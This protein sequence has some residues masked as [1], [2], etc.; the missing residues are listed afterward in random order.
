ME[1][2]GH[3]NWIYP[4][5]QFPVCLRSNGVFCCPS[6]PASST[7]QQQG[8]L[9][10]INWGKYGVYNLKQTS[11]STLEGHSSTNPQ[12]W[13]KMEKI[14]D[15]SDSEKVLLGNGGGSVWNFEWEK[16]SF[17]VE[18]LCDSINHFVCKQFPAHSHWS[19]NDNTVDIDWGKYGKYELVINPQTG[20]MS[21]FVKNNPS[22][23]RKAQF[24]RPLGLE[25]LA[26][27]PAHDHSHH[28]EHGESCSSGCKH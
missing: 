7:W 5:G 11:I 13:R 26:S 12:D 15:L 14:K 10:Q 21:G 25:A 9:I 18:F 8:D 4:S 24:L 17:E 6:F 3:Y 1:L 20:T 2:S 28:H 27:A 19:L 16:G 22:S 23:W